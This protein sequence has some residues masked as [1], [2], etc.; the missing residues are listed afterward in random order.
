MDRP[1]VS[2]LA[3]AGLHCSL[4]AILCASDLT[5]TWIGTIPKEGRRLAK[6]VAFQLVQEG[7]SLSGKAYNDG[8][9]SD[10]IIS[11]TVSDEEVS[12]EVEA[13]EQSGNQ[14][15]VV[16]YRFYGDIEGTGIELTREKA[17]ARDAASG[18]EVPV[19]RAWDSD[20]QDRARRF[21]SFRLER[22]AH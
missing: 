14:V 19:R 7:N 15:N 17:A 16:L 3:V 20:E 8:G 21:R 9:T 5:G 18:A 4:L 10:A 11:G 13:M 12:F 22:L 1:W 6:D 2:R